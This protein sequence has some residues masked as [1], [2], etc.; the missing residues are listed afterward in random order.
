MNP[1]FLCI[2]EGPLGGHE[3]KSK[4][5]EIVVQKTRAIEHLVNHLGKVK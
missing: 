5:S 2:K 1:G 4:L 3:A